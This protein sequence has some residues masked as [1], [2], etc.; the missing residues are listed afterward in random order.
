MEEIDLKELFTFI[1]SKLGLF[2]IITI[3]VCLLGCIYGLF[4]QKP[5]YK[6]DTTVILSSDTTITQN[7]INMNKNLV[8]TYAEIVK[9]RRV[10]D[11]VI[12][13]L[14]LKDIKAYHGRAEEFGHKDDYR[15]QY[16]LCVSRAVANL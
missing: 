2:I 1:K 15:E 14:D 6:S 5:L 16:D 11:K 9:S 12:E 8:N 4:I 3:S 7:D 13:E 10:L